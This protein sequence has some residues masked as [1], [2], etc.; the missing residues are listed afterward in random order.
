MKK[1]NCTQ[2]SHEYV[3]SIDP[4]FNVENIYSEERLEVRCPLCGNVQEEILDED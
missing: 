4:K 1:I 2:C 3:F